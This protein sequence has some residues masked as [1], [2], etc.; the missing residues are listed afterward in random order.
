MIITIDTTQPISA[1]D[2][3]VLAVL[4]VQS[5][6]NPVQESEEATATPEQMEKPK[7]TRRTNAQIAADKAA[8]EAQ[9][10]MG[11]QEDEQ[12]ASA[13]EPESDSDAEPGVTLEDV[14]ELATKLITSD[15]PAMVEIL[16]GRGVRRVSDVPAS[17]LDAFA[18]EI[19]AKL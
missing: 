19:R 14:T 8:A 6:A 18:D 11:K 2:R 4:L 16:K 13:P 5:V 10:E 1:L 17:D 9:S 15:R 3:G 7:R 12:T